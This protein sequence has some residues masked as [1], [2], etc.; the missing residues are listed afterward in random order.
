ME[1]LLLRESEALTRAAE[2]LKRGEV[3]AFKTETVYGLGANAFDKRAVHKIFEA[4][5]RPLDNP[6]IAHIADISMWK[7]LA[8]EIGG[9]ALSLAERFWPGPLTIILPKAMFIPDEVTAGLDTIAA[10]MPRSPFALE[11]I[12]ECGFPIAAPSANLS[13]KPSPT[14][15]AAVLEDMDGR[16]PLIADGGVCEVGVES[17]VIS[18]VDE[19]KVLRPGAVTLE[20]LREFIPD[21]VLAD[22]IAGKPMSPGM[23]YRHYAP[24]A[25]LVP[26]SGTADEQAAFLCTQYDITPNAI[27]ICSEETAAKLSSRR[28][29]ILGSRN[30]PAVI[31]SNLFESL[32]EADRRGAETI[33]MET[34]GADGAFLAFRNRV[35][36][37][38]GEN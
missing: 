37:A 20:Q 38:A 19:P 30:S 21:I 32:R 3:V 35:Q 16:I 14:T 28:H 13:G 7:S 33:F 4:K 23:K 10:R 2:L 22:S 18:L 5:G 8:R 15:A 29:I 24:L 12:R 26:A 27:V 17:T 25:K 9:G 6:L 11:L 1:T 31:L 34:F 36:R